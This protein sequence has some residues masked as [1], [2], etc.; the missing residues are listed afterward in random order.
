MAPDTQLA[1]SFDAQSA[2]ALEKAASAIE[3]AASALDKAAAS[4]QRAEQTAAKKARQAKREKQA[5]QAATATPQQRALRRIER[6]RQEKEDEKEYQKQ[7]TARGLD[8]KSSLLGGLFERYT[9]SKWEKLGGL[10]KATSLGGLALAGVQTAGWAMSRFADGLNKIN[11]PLMDAGQRFRAV[12]EGL[13]VIGGFIKGLRELQEA[14]SGVAGRIALNTRKHQLD[15]PRTLGW[16]ETMQSEYGLHVRQSGL[17]GAAET[18]AEQEKGGFAGLGV[19][20]P[21]NPLDPLQMARFGR[22]IGYARERQGLEAEGAR[23][24]QETIERNSRLQQLERERKKLAVRDESRENAIARIEEARKRGYDVS[25]RTGE[26]VKVGSN[27]GKVQLVKAA[28]DR[29]LIAQEALKVEEQIKKVKEEQQAGA[30]AVAENQKKTAENALH[31]ER[32]KLALL[33]EQGELLR[34][35]A[36]SFGRSTAGERAMALAWVKQANEKGFDS[37]IPKQVATI[38]KVYG[39]VASRWAERNYTQQAARDPNFKEAVAAFGDPSLKGANLDPVAN[40]RQQV[41]LQ[42]T[43]VELGQKVETKAA[44]AFEKAFGNSIDGL[45]KAMERIVN[46]RVAELE[47]RLKHG[48]VVRGGG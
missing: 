11:D 19:A 1:I 38:E 40:V 7:R 39:P 24:N 32:E 46:A 22:Q 2:E 42:K 31:A 34:G 27:Y 45:V 14:V 10:G 12:T 21:G 26:R 16:Y 43:L 41:E 3:K 6:E 30:L 44:A 15:T 8:E 48:E 18:L 23:L 35:T 4:A 37:L 20:D 13:P 28:E 47:A 5:E 25:Y 9:G 29:I 36:Q 17:A 33:R